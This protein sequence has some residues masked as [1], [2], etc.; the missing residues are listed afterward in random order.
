MK[1]LNNVKGTSNVY[2]FEIFLDAIV[3]ETDDSCSVQ[4]FAGLTGELLGIV[5]MK[6]E[7]L[8]DLVAEFLFV[9]VSGVPLDMMLIT[10]T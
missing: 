4:M 10:M 8:K 9:L 1:S 6:E 2:S 3:Q 5:L 7:F